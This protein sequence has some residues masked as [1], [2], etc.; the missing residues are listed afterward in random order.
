MKI[1]F[2]TPYSPREITGVGKFVDELSRAL[3]KKNVHSIIITRSAKPKIETES[4]LLEI[5]CDSVSHFKNVYLSMLTAIEL[6]KMRKTIDLIH[7][8]TPLPQSAISALLGK[9]LCIPVV[10]TIHG[11]Y[12]P[13]INIFKRIFYGFSEKITVS[14]SKK[15]VFVSKETKNYF[16]LDGIVIRNGIDI[17][18]FRRDPKIRI[19]LRKELGIGEKLAFIFVARWV[20]HKGIY[21]LLE[22]FSEIISKSGKESKLI[23]L[24]GG[25]TTKVLT[26]IKKLKIE[27]DVL[28]IGEVNEPKNYLCASD[29]FVLFTS[30]LE[31]LPL[32]LLEAM[33]CQ[34]VPIASNVSGI[35]EVIT[36]EKNGFLIKFGNRDNLFEKMM[37]CIKNKEKL[38]IMGK[39]AS[40]TIKNN[41]S[42]DKMTDE[43]LELYRSL[44]T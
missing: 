8:Q 39:N 33:S 6:F 2:V 12:P 1:C 7:L 35:P 28:P 19:K 20:S 44:I 37:W 13:A 41:H 36:D 22:I 23:L 25:E 14:N 15:I 32:A 42:L 18:N 3:K 29:V 9:I 30:P 38:S 21:D 5:N 26:K 4:E 43:Y 17:D 40:K 11:Q 10:T 34:V 16:G 27:N 31:G 24:G